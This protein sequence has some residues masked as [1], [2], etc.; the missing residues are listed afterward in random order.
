MWSCPENTVK[1]RLEQLFARVKDDETEGDPIRMGAAAMMAREIEDCMHGG[2]VTATYQGQPWFDATLSQLFSWSTQPNPITMTAAIQRL[3]NMDSLVF[4]NPLCSRLAASLGTGAWADGNDYCCQHF[5]VAAELISLC[6]IHGRPKVREF[7]LGGRQSEQVKVVREE[8]LRCLSV[9]R[10]VQATELRRLSHNACQCIANMEK[11]ISVVENTNAEDA[12]WKHPVLNADSEVYRLKESAKVLL[13]TKPENALRLYREASTLL[14]RAIADILETVS[15]SKR[16]GAVHLV[17]LEC[18]KIWSNI[19][20]LELI[21][22]RADKSL[23]A[24][25]RAC[26]S[27]KLSWK[28]HFRRGQALMALERFSEAAEAFT[29]AH[30]RPDPSRTV[31]DKSKLLKLIDEARAKIIVAEPRVFD[32]AAAVANTGRFR[33]LLDQ[34]IHTTHSTSNLTIQCVIITHPI[35]VTHPIIIMH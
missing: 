24:A 10:T 25:L 4:S 27:R 30:D 17:E 5:L 35:I 28:A 26:K 34:V 21:C 18:S 16:N 13:R 15:Q 22:G 14:D 31:T 20:Y 1:R 6:M 9:D 19:A 11:L 8:L 29:I 7:L 23:V 33:F 32:R 12:C 3:D 2:P